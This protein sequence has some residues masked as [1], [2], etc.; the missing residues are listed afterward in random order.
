MKQ[1]SE[2]VAIAPAVMTERQACEYLQVS[3]GTLRNWRLAGRLRVTK[4]G[5]TIRYPR[6]QLD[7]LIWNNLERARA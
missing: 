5:K 1:Q 4:V 7:R 6:T 2:T 3:R